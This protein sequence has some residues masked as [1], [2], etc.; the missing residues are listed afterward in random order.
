MFVGVSEEANIYFLE[1]VFYSNG[2]LGG[3]APMAAGLALASKKEII[4]KISAYL[5]AM[6]HLVREQYLKH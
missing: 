4:N 5:L 1:K 2:I 3:N 6:E